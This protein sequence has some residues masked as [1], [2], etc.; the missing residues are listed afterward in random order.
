MT[1]STAPPGGPQGKHS[2]TEAG[3]TDST[4]AMLRLIITLAL[5]TVGNG[6]IYVLAVLLPEVQKTFG[7]SGADAS[8]PQTS[9][10][11]GFALGGVLCGPLADRYGVARV[12]ALGA[13]G[14]CAGFVISG[15]APNMLVFALA[16][17]L[18][19]GLLATGSSFAPLIAD[20]ILWWNKHRGLAVGICM[21]GNLI[22]GAVWTP[23]IQWG[24]AEFGWRHVYVA[25]GP[26]CGIVMLILAGRLQPSPQPPVTVHSAAKSYRGG[27]LPTGRV[28][29][30][31]QS[32]L[33][34]GIVSGCAA[35]SFPMQQV[36]AYAMSLGIDVRL[37]VAMLAL[38]LGF[39][40]VGRVIFG[41]LS[42]HIGG[43]NTLLL[44]SALQ[45]SGLLL[46]SLF[47]GTT[48]LYVSS[49]LLGFVIGGIVPS[50]VIIISGYF[51][52]RQIGARIGVMMLGVQ[53]GLAIGGW[54]YGAVLDMTRSHPAAFFSSL[55][56]ALCHL[57]IIAAV[58]VR[59]SGFAAL[60]P[61]GR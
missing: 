4:F 52:L 45:A 9:I 47:D 5:V 34:A 54:T 56:W 20:T 31:M 55:S 38:V 26:M 22:A 23:I 33:L 46:F 53:L 29:N 39:K 27:E 19:L 44:L 2:L 58:R 40:T 21:C 14:A 59:A 28:A 42:D 49:A 57:A 18:L 11:I 7:L 10:M 60:R 51:P 24:V 41:G 13:F 35:M 3:L 37:A 36:V 12:L 61:A 15:L 43:I 6:A 25:L 8:L 16:H 1:A 50:Y 32:L 30:A 17:G 48:S